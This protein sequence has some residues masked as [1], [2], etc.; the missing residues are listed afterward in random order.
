MIQRVW[1]EDKV[2]QAV[3]EAPEARVNIEAI[4]DQLRQLSPRNDGQ[5]WLQSRALQI[6]GDIA[7]ARWLLIEQLGQ[8]A[9][10]MPFLVMLVFWLTVI[11]T[12]LLAGFLP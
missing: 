9:L 3:A 5:R 11:F 6:S 12:K 10:P 4:Q 1:P 7:E 8:R 2:G